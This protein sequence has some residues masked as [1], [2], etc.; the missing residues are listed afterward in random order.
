MAHVAWNKHN[1]EPVTSTSARGVARLERKGL[2]PSPRCN[3]LQSLTISYAR[4]LLFSLLR[5]FL[6]SLLWYTLNYDLKTTILFSLA[7]IFARYIYT[8]SNIHVRPR[9]PDFAT[10][11]IAIHLSTDFRAGERQTPRSPSYTHTCTLAHAYTHT[12]TCKTL[13]QMRSRGKVQR[14]HRMRLGHF[15]GVDC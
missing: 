1:W 2:L 8:Y 5:L 7:C 13:L 3:V 9:L 15:L 12:H 6:Y 10:S 11:L 4:S 14:S